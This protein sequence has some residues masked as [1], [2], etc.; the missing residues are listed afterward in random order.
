[1]RSQTVNHSHDPFTKVV[2]KLL[3]K[4]MPLSYLE[5]YHHYLN[6]VNNINW[7]KNPK[8]IF[9]S[10]SFIDDDFFKIWLAGKKEKYNVKFISG[11]HGG[12]FFTTKFSFFEK[13]QSKISDLILTWGY[14]KKKCQPLFN[15]KTANKK[16][17]FDKNGNLL[18][19][20]YEVS[21]FSGGHSNYLGFSYL[22]YLKDQ[23]NLIKNLDSHVLDR[24]VLREYPHDLGWNINLKS[25]LKDNINLDVSIDKN[26]KFYN[27]L[28]KSKICI[29]NLN[30]TIF[31]ETLN[32][33][34]PTVLFFNT[35][36]EPVNKETKM[37]FNI[38]KQAGI[39]FDDYWCHRYFGLWSILPCGR[40]ES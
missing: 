11:Q 32:L 21:R 34:F 20:Q 15:F 31:L 3:F 8:F 10:C 40:V 30:S 38:L 35:N 4:Y 2:A 24:L 1:M 36:N 23:Y 17:D 22:T 18:F 5:N 14:N 37:Y 7:P 26:K 16:V 25:I 33:N 13:H 19:I 29:V 28:S 6:R 9:S 27:S 39:F 12:S